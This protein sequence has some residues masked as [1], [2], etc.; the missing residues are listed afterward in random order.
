MQQSDFARLSNM[1]VVRFLSKNILQYVQGK[2]QVLLSKI[3]QECIKFTLN[4]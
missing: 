2:I 4:P 1:E 3:V